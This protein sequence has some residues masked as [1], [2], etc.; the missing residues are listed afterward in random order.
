MADKTD[1]KILNILQKEGRIPFQDLGERVGLTRQAVTRRVN[2]M[3]AD[4]SIRRFTVDIDHDRLGKSLIAY[5]DIIF[6]GPFTTEVE[7]NAIEFVSK[8]NGVRL[9]NTT[10]GEKYITAKFRTR[11]LKELDKIIRA[12]NNAFEGVSTRTVIVNDLF[13]SNKAV[14]YPEE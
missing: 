1:H 5:V 7:E 6:K 9:A 8:I 3:V 12:L 2:K 10:V 13:F 14:F 11:D 4:G